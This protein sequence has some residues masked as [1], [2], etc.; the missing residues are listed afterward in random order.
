MEADRKPE[1][2]VDMFPELSVELERL[3]RVSGEHAWQSKFRGCAFCVDAAAGMIS[4]P[5]FIRNPNPK[6]LMD[7]GCG[8]WLLNQTLGTSSSM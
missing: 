6:G 3:L 8:P 1:L 4:A 5:H 2:L 7:P